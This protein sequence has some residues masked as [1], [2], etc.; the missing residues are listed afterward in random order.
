MI[1]LSQD[2]LKILIYTLNGREAIRLA[3]GH[4]NLL[5]ED[6]V[7]IMTTSGN[8]YI[9]NCVTSE[10]EKFCTWSRNLEQNTKLIFVNHEFGYPFNQLE[11]LKKY[12]LPIIEDCAHSFFTKDPQNVIGTIG[13]FVIFSFPKMFPIQIGGLLVQKGDFDLPKSRLLNVSETQYIKN[14]L[15]H[16]IQNMDEIIEKRKLNFL[17]LSKEFR[18]LGFKERFLINEGIV[19]GVFMFQA[20]GQK[21][22]LQMLKEHFYSNG[23]Q[24][25]VF[26]GE[27][28][29]FIPV[30]QA[31]NENDLSYFV[32]VMKMF[33]TRI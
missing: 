23:I 6:V 19:P 20:N 31:L 27:E 18:K 14:V 22:D 21:I 3:L 15:S 5:P 13:D 30:N 4:Y 26:Y 11:G 25:S 9:S 17:Y 28:S 24:C 2:S 1:T 16:Y 29:F 33:L 32:E 10:I 12:D 7:T 8:S